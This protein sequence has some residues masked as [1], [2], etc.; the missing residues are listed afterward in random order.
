MGKSK[1]TGEWFEEAWC[2]DVRTELEKKIMP[3]RSIWNI[4]VAVIHNE[5]A[6]KLKMIL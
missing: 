2:D 6:R 3:L 4:K 5:Q 1:E